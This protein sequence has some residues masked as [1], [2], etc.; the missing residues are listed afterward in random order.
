MTFG[1]W[2]NPAAEFPI[3][4]T[5]DHVCHT[6]QITDSTLEAAE[7]GQSRQPGGDVSL[8]HGQFASHL[9]EWIREGSVTA[10]RRMARDDCAA[11]Y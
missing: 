7:N 6:I 1:C 8:L 3:P 9:A 4:N 10:L 5:R 11:A 2:L